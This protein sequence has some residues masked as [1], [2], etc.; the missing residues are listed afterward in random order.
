[1]A[2]LRGNHGLTGGAFPLLVGR[3][4]L[5]LV[6]L[7]LALY[8]YA[9]AGAPLASPSPFAVPASE[10]A[11]LAVQPASSAMDR[12]PET[13]ALILTLEPGSSQV[14]FRV[15]EQL[16]GQRLPGEA[17]GT[18]SAVSG[19]LAFDQNGL[20]V[21]EQSRITVD[22]DS[23]QS[24]ERRR[25]SYIKRATLQTNQFPT[26]R[27]VPRA[28]SGLPTPLPTAG[29]ASF[30]LSGDLSVH[31]V[32]R[33]TVWQVTARFADEA[34]AGTAWTSVNITDFGMQP[35]KAGP[36]L[37]VDDTIT[38]QV[39]F[40]TAR[41]GRLASRPPQQRTSSP[42]HS[43]PFEHLEA[44]P[45]SPLSKCQCANAVNASPEL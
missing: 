23:L 15:R 43:Q 27:F 16:V 29:E 42:E 31:G 36:V 21:G 38:L 10:P 1:V 4:S 5:L 35:P 14:S 40:T 32:T 30:E 26:A 18:T 37:S 33:P 45:A 19:R 3:L 8:A 6:V 2:S 7:A 20:I 28:A 17:I 24:D 25:D 13:A 34:I 9:R 11:L 44:A 41:S 12:A 22:L 39:D